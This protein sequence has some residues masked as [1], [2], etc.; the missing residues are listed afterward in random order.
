MLTP[1]DMGF[2]SPNWEIQ[3]NYPNLVQCTWTIQVEV[4]R[5]IQLSF[6]KH[7]TELNHD[8]VYVYDAPGTLIPIAT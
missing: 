1:N 6:V 3:G 8:I 5:A 2:Y 7:N 4:G